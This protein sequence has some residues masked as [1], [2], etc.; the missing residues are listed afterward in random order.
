MEN[1]SVKI[2]NNYHSCDSDDHTGYIKVKNN[3]LYLEEPS[4]YIFYLYD[5]EDR[6]KR[7]RTFNE[8]K[9][10]IKTYLDNFNTDNIIRIT[11]Y[12]NNMEETKLY[13]MPIFTNIYSCSNDLNYD[14][15]HEYIKKYINLN[16]D[17]EVTTYVGE[18]AEKV[19]IQVLRNMLPMSKVKS[20][21]SINY[22]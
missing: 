10:R 15:I 14:K 8:K 18:K 22:T 2:V 11:I 19:P 6:E 17:I 7:L 20:A 1:I 16:T 4:I 13:N 21:R 5:H 3:F 9:D 12:T